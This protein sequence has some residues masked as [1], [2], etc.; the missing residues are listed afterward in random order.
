M[1]IKK[2][3]HSINKTNNKINA[4]R[5]VLLNI[6]KKVLLEHNSC[7]ASIFFFLCP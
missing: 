1:I 2:Y 5:N 3:I 7:K 4:V 6:F